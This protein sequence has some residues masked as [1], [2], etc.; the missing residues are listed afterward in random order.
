MSEHLVGS[1]D[2]VGEGAAAGAG[3]GNRSCVC[4]RGGVRPINGH[5]SRTSNLP[6]KTQRRVDNKMH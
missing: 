3:L 1:A 5:D 4:G 2:G 6:R